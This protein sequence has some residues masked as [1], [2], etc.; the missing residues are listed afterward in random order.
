MLFCLFIR[1]RPLCHC[2]ITNFKPFP[3]HSQNCTNNKHCVNQGIIISLRWWQL[4]IK[5]RK[6]KQ[7]VKYSS[8]ED[9]FT[10]EFRFYHKSEQLNIW[11]ACSMMG[12]SMYAQFYSF[13]HTLS[14]KQTMQ[15]LKLASL[16]PPN[17]RDSSPLFT[18]T[19]R[20]YGKPKR[21]LSNLLWS[22]YQTTLSV[23]YI[24]MEQN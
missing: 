3:N 6:Y 22:L 9:E 16:D 5:A 17:E 14:E 21:I 18:E 8:E 15:I 23:H 10:E 12:V 2:V 19:W 20:T 4:C 24:Q 7:S 1:T 11:M 13:S